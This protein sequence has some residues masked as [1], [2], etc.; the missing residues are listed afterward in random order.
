MATRF[1]NAVLIG[2][3]LILAGRPVQSSAEEAEPPAIPVLA[4]V[5][6]RSYYVGQAIELRI[7]AEA[8]AERP[9]VIA[10]TIP[11]TDVFLIDTSFSPV[12]ATGIGDVTSE[13]DLFVTRF[14]LIP[15]RAGT[16]GIPPVVVRLGNRSGVSRPLSLKVESPPLAGRPA[17]FL[18]GIGAF[19]V[20]AGATPTD[21]R[22]GEEFTYT[23]T[24]TGPGARGM[25]SR[26]DLGRFRQ[27]PLGLEVEPVSPVGVNSPPSRRFAYR[28]RATRAGAASLPPVAVAAFDPLAG[29]YVTRVTP[30]VAIRIVDVPR[31]DPATVDYRP[32]PARE[33][34]GL[35]WGAGIRWAAVAGIALGAVVAGL[36]AARIIYR[37]WSLDPSWWLRRRGRRL[38]PFDDPARTAREI[39]A[40]LGAYI[41]RSTGRSWGVLTPDEAGSAIAEVTRDSDLGARVGRLVAGC[42]R[43]CYSDRQPPSTE[44]VAQARRLFEEIGTR[45]R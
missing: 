18:G 23:I 44:L 4:Q 26:P 19:A 35:A 32:P 33:G 31:F 15:R 38:R 42:D 1:R 28:I 29:Q 30:S 8:A 9:Q 21:V 10:P 27:V 24:V 34:R 16:L 45:N 39:A 17:A 41:E 3:G 11:D 12:A 7:G 37:R 25:T 6:A 40:A 13:R 22:L 2:I 14:R 43:A 36:L 5:P 20:E